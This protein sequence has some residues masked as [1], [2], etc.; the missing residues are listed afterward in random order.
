MTQIPVATQSDF[1]RLVPVFTERAPHVQTSRRNTSQRARASGINT[2]VMRGMSSL[3]IG[4]LYLSPNVLSAQRP[5]LSETTSGQRVQLVLRD[6]LRQGPLLPAR[7]LITG[8][9]VRANAD[10]VWI[11][12]YGA[13][14]FGLPRP[15]IKYARVSRGT[16]RV[17]SALTLGFG[18][19]IS[20]AAAVALDGID[21]D[22][23]ANNGRDALIG[24]GVGF[25]A[26]AIIGSVR[27]FEHWRSVRR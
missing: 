13:S 15:L 3:L 25:G 20:F 27:P 16:S 5:T 6:S 1:E 19:G 23:D 22:D 11:R 26:G 24:A 12:P 7:Q 18:W 10:S 8:K 17:R 2:L 14:E 4:A 9:F 21:D